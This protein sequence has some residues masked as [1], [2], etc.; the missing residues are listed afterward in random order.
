MAIFRSSPADSRNTRTPPGVAL[1]NERPVAQ[2][3]TYALTD[4]GVIGTVRSAEALDVNDAGQVVGNSGSKAFLWQDGVMTDLGSLGGTASVAYAIN[5]VGQIVGQS[6]TPNNAARHAALWDH[7]AIVDLLPGVAYSRA[8]AINDLREI[9][10]ETCTF[11]FLWRNGA[12]TDLGS[13]G[14]M[15]TYANDINDAGQIVGASY[16]NETTPLGPMAHAYVWQNNVMTD[17]G[18]L[19]GLDDSGAS[20][21]N[22][23]GVIVGSSSHTDPDT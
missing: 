4:L 10:G 7:G 15:A 9:V 17:L 5:G 21:I 14:G 22:S 18:V 12:V 8:T 2:S 16:T 13:L 11:A 19:A 23:D 1:Q 6:S 3:A 20:A